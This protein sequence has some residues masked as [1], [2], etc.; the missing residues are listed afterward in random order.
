MIGRVLG[1][2]RV[3]EAIGSGGMGAVYRAHDQRLDRDVAIKVLPPDSLADEE[4][5]KRFQQEALA[6]S[7]ISHPNIETVYDFASEDGADYLVMELVPGVSLDRKLASGPLSEGEILPLAMQLTEGLAAAHAAGV[8]H[9]DLKPHNVQIT[10]QGRLKILDFGL[11]KRLRLTS[12]AETLDQLTR[13]RGLLGTLPY[14]SPEQLRG[15]PVDARTDIYGAGAVLYEMATRQRPFPESNSAVLAENIL[16]RQ[17][18]P[19]REINPKISVK[20]EQIIL[21]CLAK[22]GVRRYSSAAELGADLR[23]AEGG[24]QGVWPP[25]ALMSRARLLWLLSSTIVLVLVALLSLH[26]FQRGANPP[27]QRIALAVVPFRSLSNQP[28]V[29]F[30]RVGLADAITTKLSNINRLLLRPTSA[31]LRFQESDLQRAGRELGTEYVVSGTL[32]SAGQRYGVSAQ[33]IRVSDGTAVW[34]ERFDVNRTGLLSLE[35]DIAGRIAAALN[36]QLAERER[37]RFYQR[38]T[39]NAEAYEQ[40]LTGRARLAALTKEATIAAIENF[41]AALHLDPNY[42][43]AH[44]GLAIA[45]ATM[46]IRF[47]EQAEV[48]Q[49]EE[50]ARSEAQRALSLDPDLAEAHEALAAVFRNAEFDWDRV[51]SE[52][53][54]ALELNPN[55]ETPHYYK[56][57]AYYHLGLLEKVKPE[58]DEGL[59]VNPSNRVEPLRLGGSSAL[60]SGDFE[61]A[62]QA[63]SEVRRLSGGAVSDWYLSQALYYRGEQKMALEM[64]RGIRGSAQAE[65]RAKATLASFLAAEGRRTEAKELLVAVEKGGYMDHHVAYSLGA[66]YAQLGD[67]TQAMHWLTVSSDTGFPC[68]PWFERDPLLTPLRGNPDFKRFL[69]SSRSGLEK[70]RLRYAQ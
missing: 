42:A 50:L 37:A 53:S 48:Q 3:I 65:A 4:S 15:Q 41:R 34:G 30:L 61:R 47:A 36:I 46:R 26:Y 45:A 10:P 55:L 35:E 27:P 39:A 59:R 29:D 16:N 19:P 49:W 7:S 52:S 58:L 32:Q 8:L 68:F 57:A 60:F 11:A 18:Q 9:R 44:A 67:A 28:E 51:L 43:L 56:A 12:D 17:P 2:Y 13:S 31:V 23:L 33:L 14:M 24:A 70:A 22:E 64:L 5:R 66:G 20:L 63:L 21:K 62:D 38:Y 1:H 54:R 40:Y 25:G 6:L 69:N